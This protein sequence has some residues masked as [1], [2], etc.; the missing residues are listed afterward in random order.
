V[1]VN[2]SFGTLGTH[3]RLVIKRV[4]YTCLAIEPE[5]ILELV[6]VGAVGVVCSW[7]KCVRMKTMNAWIFNAYM[8]LELLEFFL[9]FQNLLRLTACGQVSS[10]RGSIVE[11]L[12]T[13]W[14]TNTFI[15][16]FCVQSNTQI[17]QYTNN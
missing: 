3:D 9:L 7:E 4:G 6:L 10:E 11:N 16:H 15:P 8:L 5:P 2:L 14:M 12:Q 13:L 1:Q 17:S